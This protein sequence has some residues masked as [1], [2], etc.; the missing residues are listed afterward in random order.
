M[1]TPSIATH[2]RDVILSAYLPDTARAYVLVDDKYQRAT[3]QNPPVV[4]AQELLLERCATTPS[5]PSSQDS[6]GEG[7]M[8]VW[9][10]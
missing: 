7:P 8:L 1:S 10:K 9:T 2:L 5:T 4:N 6:S 3:G